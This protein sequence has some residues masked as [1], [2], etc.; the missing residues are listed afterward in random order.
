MWAE[1][2]SDSEPRY[3]DPP[4]DFDRA[5]DF[6][7]WKAW[8]SSGGLEDFAKEH[9]LAPNFIERLLL[10]PEDIVQKYRQKL[11]DIPGLKA[12]LDATAFQWTGSMPD[13]YVRKFM[14]WA[15]DGEDSDDEDESES[16]EMTETSDTPVEDEMEKLE[17]ENEKAG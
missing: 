5:R 14:A 12:K 16:A 10:V 17:C 11:D 2:R 3:S 6:D 4:S 9:N 1:P 13:K 7:E 15:G 8:V